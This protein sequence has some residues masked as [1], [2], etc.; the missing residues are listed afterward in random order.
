MKVFR[1]AL[2]VA[3]LTT[4][5]QLS[6]QEYAFKV[7]VNKGKNE[8]KSGETWQQVKVGSSLQSHDKLKV[9]E[10]S[11]LGL[12]H[13]SGKPLELKQSGEYKVVDLAARVTGGPS[14]LNKYTD[15]ILS[16]NT[17]PK[18]NLTA[19]GAVSRGAG[20]IDV[21]LPNPDLSVVYGNN[22]TISWEDNKALR[23]YVVI[24]KSMFGD[25][26]NVIETEQS[27]VVVNLDDPNFVNED[28]IIVTVASKT[29]KTKIS[30]EYTLKKLSKADKERIKSLLNE[31]PKDMW[32]PTALNKLVI[33][34]IFEQ[35]GLLIDAN[36][37]FLE[38]IKLAPDVTDFKDDHEAFLIRHKMK[39]LPPKK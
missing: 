32:E 8:L 38:A 16:T 19:T 30:D 9:A 4:A 39:R 28:N 31:V 2:I 33:G 20:S 36:S 12:V 17:G 7:L 13:V 1:L 18:T 6:A 11:Y 23:P 14:V 24:F 26:L 35:N 3:S 29:D 10:N 21:H 15:F 34:G 25:E 27:H 37:Y 22:V 5:G